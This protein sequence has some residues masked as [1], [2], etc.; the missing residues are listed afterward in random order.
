MD[1][2]TREMKAAQDLPAAQRAERLRPFLE[3]HQAARNASAETAAVQRFGL[4]MGPQMVRLNQLDL[5]VQGIGAFFTDEVA[6]ALKLSADQQQRM[7]TVQSAYE[8][9]FRPLLKG[10][11][12]SEAIVLHSTQPAIV[13]LLKERTGKV[14]EVLSKEQ[15]ENPASYPPNEGKLELFRDI[16]SVAAKIDEMVTE[17]KSGG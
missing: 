17:L 13:E 10:P 15:L 14:E 7:E 4:L 3:S 12:Y 1:E 2:M 11:V 5:Q 9:K 6:A 16:G 8:A